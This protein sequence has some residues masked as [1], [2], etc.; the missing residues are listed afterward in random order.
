MRRRTHALGLRWREAAAAA[1]IAVVAF[2]AGVYLTAAGSIPAAAVL[3]VEVAHHRLTTVA[4]TVTKRSGL[5][6]MLTMPGGV[7]KEFYLD[8]STKVMEL[9]DP[10]MRSLGDVLVGS[11]VVVFT[12]PD[13]SSDVA[14]SIQL[15]PVSSTTLP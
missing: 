11:K 2:C 5:S 1:G 10:I 7:Q 6:F 13:A 4:G 8:A 15:I 3:R 12:A 9:P 14:Q